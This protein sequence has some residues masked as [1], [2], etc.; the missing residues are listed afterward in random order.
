VAFY[1]DTSA[2]LK[3][4][5]TEAESPAMRA[6]FTADRSCWSSQILVTEALR[7][8]QRLGLDLEGV[9]QAL[10]SVSLVLPSATTFHRTGTVVPPSLRSLD[11]LHVASAME[12]GSDLEAVVAYD[13]RLIEGAVAAGLAVLSPA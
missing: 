7:A 13:A 3:L 9:N 1:L 12:L 4:L 10:D 5:V 2:F 6:W 8:G 11:A